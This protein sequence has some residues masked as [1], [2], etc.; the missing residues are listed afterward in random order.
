MRYAVD[1]V[2][3]FGRQI[4]QASYRDPRWA[5]MPLGPAGALEVSLE[6][7]DAGHLREDVQLSGA[8]SAALRSAVLGTVTLIGGHAFTARAAKSRLRI[9]ATITA[10][11][12][13]DDWHGKSFA[14]SGVPR[15][16]NDVAQAFFAYE[17]RRVDFTLKRLH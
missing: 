12:V 5:A 3:T 2:D 17:G 4:P 16:V 9:T 13:G 7:D 15:F 11:V 14:S 10:D 6:I 1:L 8:P